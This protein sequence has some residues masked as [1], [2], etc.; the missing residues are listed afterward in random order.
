MTYNY[1][2]LL[3]YMLYVFLP[4]YS[5]ENLGNYYYDKREIASNWVKNLDTYALPYLKE[6]LVSGDPE[7][8]YRCKYILEDFIRP[9]EGGHI[10]IFWLSNDKRYADNRDI[11]DEYY[12]AAFQKRQ[13]EFAERYR[14]FGWVKDEFR[15]GLVDVEEVAT[16]D[17]F[18]DLRLQGYTRQQIKELNEEMRC[19]SE[20]LYH[21]EEEN[22]VPKRPP[23]PL[24]TEKIWEGR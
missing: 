3:L 14:F 7:I 17:Y 15:Y 20:T 21:A 1:A 4:S 19:N 22:Y 2:E 6:G 13:E 12:K 18:A 23:S 8:K 9:L 24:L 5:V 16:M 11:S 10:G